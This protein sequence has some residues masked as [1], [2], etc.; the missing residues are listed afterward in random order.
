MPR[1]RPGE[2]GDE[3]SG[4]KEGEDREEATRNSAGRQRQKEEMKEGDDAMGTVG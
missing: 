2:K 3:L 4:K 1:V